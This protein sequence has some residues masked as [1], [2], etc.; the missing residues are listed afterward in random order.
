[1]PWHLRPCAALW[2]V[3]ACAWLALGTWLALPPEEVERVM[4]ETGPVERLTAA[5]YGLCAAAIW[6][7][8]RP[9]DDARS[10]LAAS[11]VM[12]A[13]CA[14][15]LDW[16]RTFTGTSVLRV[17]W[18]AGPASPA[19]KLVAGAAVA[20]FAAA[21][22]WLLWRH[23]R[24]VLRGLLQRRPL[25]VTLTV[26]VGTLVLA[27]GLDRSVGIL[28]DDFGVDV[29]LHWK[30]LRSAFE[31]WFELALSMLVTLVLLQRRGEGGPG[32]PAPAR[33]PGA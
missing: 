25:S 5:T 16:H 23:A 21:L 14:R 11:T 19:V 3:A 27:K 20:A 15:E 8:R 28:V 18:Y 12:L 2:I 22:A 13:F 9:G 33:D 31:E 1:M 24:S 26:F 32:T 30:A 6:F 29:P 4:G 7:A 10:L 17:S